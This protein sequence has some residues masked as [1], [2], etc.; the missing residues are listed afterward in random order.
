MFDAL[1]RVRR[2]AERPRT[3]ADAERRHEKSKEIIYTYLCIIERTLSI[4]KRILKNR[5]EE[6]E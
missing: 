2:D 6:G 5:D 4:V 3:R 1:R